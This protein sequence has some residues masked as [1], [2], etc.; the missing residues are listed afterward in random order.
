[1]RKQHP[2][3]YDFTTLVWHTPLPAPC[4]QGKLRI[5]LGEE[6]VLA[7]LAH[8]AVLQKEGPRGSSEAIAGRLEQAAQIVKQV[9]S[10]QAVTS[11]VACMCRCRMHLR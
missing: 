4:A 6:T 1:M 10:A 8:A 2:C 11:K 3:W 5:G 9:G 7:A